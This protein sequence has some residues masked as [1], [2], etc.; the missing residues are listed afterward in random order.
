MRAV[1]ASLSRAPGMATELIEVMARTDGGMVAD[2]DRPDLLSTARWETD[3]GH[4]RAAPTAEAATPAAKARH[5]SQS[6]GR[7]TRIE[8]VDTGL[9]PRLP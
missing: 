8:D 9:C 3:G 1:A 5:S 4:P 6:D 7:T 2:V